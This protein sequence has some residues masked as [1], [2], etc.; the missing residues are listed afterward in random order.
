LVWQQYLAMPVLCLALAGVWGPHVVRPVG[1]D[2]PAMA[3]S[4]VAV[5][6]FERHD[7]G[8]WFLAIVLIVTG[9][10]GW[11]GAMSLITERVR[12]PPRHKQSVDK[13]H[14]LYE[15]TIIRIPMDDG[16][17]GG[18]LGT[19]GAA[20]KRRCHLVRGYTWGK[21]TR[22]VEEQ[23]WIKPFWRGDRSVGT[24]ERSHYVVG[25]KRGG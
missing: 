6:A 24:I 17:E 7:G 8:F 3:V 14:R 22:P 2:L 9:A 15:H 21:N 13:R 23:R 18:D 11:F 10:V 12:V 19:G 25:G 16:G 5:A 4:I 20:R 1:V